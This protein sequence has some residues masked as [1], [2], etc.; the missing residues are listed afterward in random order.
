MKGSWVLTLADWAAVSRPQDWL[1]A[2]A[3]QALHRYTTNQA[4]LQWTMSVK[5]LGVTFR[6]LKVGRC[7]AGMAP[8]S[9][10]M[11]G[12][13]SDRHGRVG[14][15]WPKEAGPGRG[16]SDSPGKNTGGRG[17]NW[18]RSWPLPREAVLHTHSLEGWWPG[19]QGS[20]ESRVGGQDP[21]EDMAPSRRGST[22]A[23][24]IHG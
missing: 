9:D 3:W 5:P 6:R 7:L 19:W 4:P 24:G 23:E 2:G 22:E 11:D 8:G 18:T 13:S 20:L 12:A 16:C 1:G 14:Q 17:W 21:R 10:G 15:K